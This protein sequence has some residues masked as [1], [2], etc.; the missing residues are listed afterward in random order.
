MKML[1]SLVKDREEVKGFFA[2]GAEFANAEPVSSAWKTTDQFLEIQLKDRMKFAGDVIQK[3]VQPLQK[4]IVEAN[5]KH[6]SLNFQQKAWKRELHQNEDDI[7]AQRE[8][9]RDLLESC[10]RAQID[11]K[12]KKDEDTEQ[13]G[14]SFFS[15]L[16][17]GVAELYRGSLPE[18]HRKVQIC[19]HQYISKVGSSNKR[20]EKYL[21]LDLIRVCHEYRNLAVTTAANLK[22]FLG[23]YHQLH[24]ESKNK[25][26]HAEKYGKFLESMQASGGLVA[27]IKK[28]EEEHKKTLVKVLKEERYI[29]ELP[30]TF[31]EVKRSIYS[32]KGPKPVGVPRTPSLFS[33][34][35]DQIIKVQRENK[36]L[37]AVQRK[38]R[39]PTPMDALIILIKKL[40]GLKTEGIFRVSAGERDLDAM[41]HTLDRGF[42]TGKYKFFTNSPHVPAV[43]LKRWLRSL[44][45]TLIPAGMYREAMSLM[46]GD[47]SKPSAEKIDEVGKFVAKLPQTHRDVLKTLVAFAHEIDFHSAENRMN[48]SNL[49]VV[50]GPC[51]I[52][53]PNPNVQQ[54]VNDA[55][56]SGSFT[57]L[58]LH[59]LKP[60]APSA[61]PPL[62]SGSPVTE[63][64]E[65]VTETKEN[66]QPTP[67]A[68]K[69][70]GGENAAE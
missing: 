31:E 23:S 53:N 22:T 51:V 57:L 19:I 61:P 10:H 49:A 43:M 15:K 45:V 37:P 36:A 60:P 26:L 27:A 58:L 42:I 62:P 3:V 48:L 21:K 54:L 24:A 5:K 12:K 39:I 6:R 1:Q 63:K 52:Q 13:G 56:A 32:K 40:N 2:R 4:W 14:I 68:S 38:M 70:Q 35:L 7:I 17:M 64:K 20:I 8:A 66:V 29:Y 30:V 18:L 41:K 33:S 28:A 46:D 55:R 11:E 47:T 69:E 67:E 25:S 44:K 9:C 59:S 50:L 34:T 65:G 16:S